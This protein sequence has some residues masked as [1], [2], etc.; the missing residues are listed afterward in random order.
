MESIFAQQSP[1]WLHDVIITWWLGYWCEKT[2]G[3]SNYSITSQRQRPQSKI[4]GQQ[5]T[6]FATPFFWNYVLDGEVRGAPG[7]RPRYRPSRHSDPPDTSRSHDNWMVARQTS[8]RQQ[9]APPQTRCSKDVTAHPHRPGARP[10]RPCPVPGRTAG[11]R[12]PAGADSAPHSE[13]NFF[14]RVLLTVTHDLHGGLHALLRRP[15][16]S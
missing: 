3:L 5:K 14:Y 4:D 6:F 1:H 7:A 9:T 15:R 8:C 11:S 12:C 2:G 16:N 13:Q 10:G